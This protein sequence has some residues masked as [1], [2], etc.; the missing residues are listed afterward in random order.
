MCASGL[1]TPRCPLLL[2]L[3][4][5]VLIEIGRPGVMYGEEAWQTTYLVGASATLAT[6]VLS[7][8]CVAHMFTWIP[9]PED[10]WARDRVALFLHQGCVRVVPWA[11]HCVW[12]SLFAWQ[13]SVAC[14]GFAKWGSFETARADIVLVGG[15]A[16]ACV[17]L[18]FGLLSLRANTSTVVGGASNSNSSSSSI[19]GGAGAAG[20]GGGGGG[21]GGRGGR[22][23]SVVATRNPVSAQEVEL[24][25]ATPKR[26]T[27]PS[28]SPSPSPDSSRGARRV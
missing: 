12:A 5:F 27:S 23:G 16:A 26:G 4:G 18:V 21:R 25:A 15:A 11:F 22:G 2:P 8:A 14:M 10:D 19:S 13:V 20:G 7:L 1:L 3:P 9:Y 28:P 17:S 6:G 24:R